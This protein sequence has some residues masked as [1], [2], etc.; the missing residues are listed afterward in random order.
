[1]PAGERCVVPLSRLG[2]GHREASATREAV[3]PGARAEP[4][5]LGEPGWDDPACG[6]CKV[7]S[8]CGPTGYARCYP[9]LP[10][11]F[12]V[13]QPTAMCCA[14]WTTR[15]SLSSSPVD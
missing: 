4:G 9:L 2:A 13:W 1:R 15:R 3:S 7:G 10:N 12:P 8:A 11:A 5:D 6:D 14:W